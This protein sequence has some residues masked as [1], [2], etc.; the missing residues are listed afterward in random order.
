MRHRRTKTL[1]RQAAAGMLVAVALSCASCAYYNTFFFAEKYYKQAERARKDRTGDNPTSSEI[2]FY[3]KCVRQ[4]SKLISEYPDSKYVDDALYLMASSYYY[5]RRYQDALDWFG[6]LE[7]SY[8]ESDLLPEVRYMTALCHLELGEYVEAENILTQIL[9]TARG[10]ERDRIVFALS[11]VALG[12]KELDRAVHYLTTLLEGE[13]SGRLRL[14]AS[15]E[16]GD[17]Y[18]E[19]GAYDS[20]AM[21]YEIVAQGSGKREERVEARKRMG[22]AWQ[23][24]GDC[25]RALEI[26]SRLLLSVEKESEKGKKRDPQEAELLLR[27]GECHNSLGEHE[28]ALELFERVMEDFSKTSMA[29]E[30]EFLTGYTHEI[31]Y[32]DLD[33]AKISYDRVPSHSPNSVFVNEAERRS[34]GLGQLKQYLESGGEAAVG[35]KGESLYLSAELNLF[36]LNKPEKALEIYREVESSYP[37][38]PLAPKAAY[39]AA[40]VLINKLDREEEGMDE[41]RRLAEEYPYTDYAAGARRIL[42]MTPLGML[43]QGPPLPRG[44]T[45]PDSTALAR[46]LERAAGGSGDSTG[47]GAGADTV[48][49]AAADTASVIGVSRPGGEAGPGDT[50]VGAPGDTAGT[51]VARGDSAAAANA[52]SVGTSRPDTSGVADTPDTSGV[53]APPDTS[54]AATPPDTT[55]TES[56]SGPSLAP[57]AADSP[58]GE[59]SRPDSTGGGEAQGNGGVEGEGTGTG[60]GTGGRTG[61]SAVEGTGESAIEEKEGRP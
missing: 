28:R 5:W 34:E 8:P 49:Y 11:D 45:P 44:W 3:E 7:E 17:A 39:A 35:P 59:G 20:A 32:E 33:R 4:C 41:Y 25:E 55:G 23:A 60:G 57:G 12:R 2:G 61:E 24:R 50:R 40:W 43:V 31:Y 30:A 22:Q 51:R 58:A 46:L 36:Q 53:A 56:N 48:A 54:G 38:S 6:Q 47:T 21:S 9:A 16:L 52:D 26:Y 27:M 14:D 29:A 15:L 42:G 10:E 37:D 18:F 1:I 13:A 19:K